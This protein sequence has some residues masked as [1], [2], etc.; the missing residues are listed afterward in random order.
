VGNEDDKL[1][2]YLYK[3][4]G[5]NA[6]DLNKLDKYV[7][8]GQFDIL[9]WCKNQVDEYPILAKIAR[10]LLA[11]QVSTVASE[12]AFSAGGC[13]IDPFRSHLEPE[14]VE[15]LICMMD[16]VAAARRGY[17]IC[18]VLVAVLE[19]IIILLADFVCFGFSLV[20]R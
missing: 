1:K 8:S 14:M 12:S 16:W 7:A 19:C 5:P 15:G 13:V 11:I 6:D 20:F 10:D 9:S 3:S 2:S 18:S 4:C 17:K